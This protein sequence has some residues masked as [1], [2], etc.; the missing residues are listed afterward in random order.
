M[1]KLSKTE[2]KKRLEEIRQKRDDEEL[3]KVVLS[4]GLNVKKAYK[5]H[6]IK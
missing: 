4:I 6:Y 3:E 5:S 2:F 1:V